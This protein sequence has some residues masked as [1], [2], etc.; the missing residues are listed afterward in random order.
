MGSMRK[1]EGLMLAIDPGKD[2]RRTVYRHGCMPYASLQVN[3][4]LCFTL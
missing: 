3:P 4:V 1:Y 2:Y